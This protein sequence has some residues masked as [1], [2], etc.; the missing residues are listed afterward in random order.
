MRPKDDRG[1][2]AEL[3]LQKPEQARK[4]ETTSSRLSDEALP[5]HSTF[6]IPFRSTSHS[7]SST[8]MAAAL[9][10]PLSIAALYAAPLVA[11][12]VRRGLGAIFRRYKNDLPI[13]PATP[14][15]LLKNEYPERDILGNNLLAHIL[16]ALGLSVAMVIAAEKEMALR[17]ADAVT[18]GLR[19]VAAGLMS[20]SIAHCV[21]ADMTGKP[22]GNMRRTHMLSALPLTVGTL[23]ANYM[24]NGTVV[25]T[26]FAANRTGWWMFVPRLLLSKYFVIPVFGFQA[27]VA[28]YDIAKSFRKPAGKKAGTEN[29]EE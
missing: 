13:K 3:G 1:D 25:E 26:V 19:A 14:S 6:H 9:L 15:E 24:M 11:P 29:K 22:E 5:Q 12:A 20:D 7:L 8:K 21:E 4:S 10:R 23:A 27:A 18:L 17:G 16:G 28:V 2:A